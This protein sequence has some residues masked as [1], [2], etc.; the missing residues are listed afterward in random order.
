L[1]KFYLEKAYIQT[2]ATMYH[3]RYVWIFCRRVCLGK[4]KNILKKQSLP[5]KLMQPLQPHAWSAAMTGM[6][7]KPLL[8]K[9]ETAILERCSQ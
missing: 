1:L 8:R 5:L 2:A 3:S 7:E 9:K 4:T 6:M